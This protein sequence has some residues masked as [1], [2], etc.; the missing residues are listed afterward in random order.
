MLLA[1]VGFTEETVPTIHLVKDYGGAPRKI[2]VYRTSLKSFDIVNE[3]SF[4][5]QADIPLPND[6]H[7]LYAHGWVHAQ[8]HAPV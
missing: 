3:I 8:R 4:H 7:I 2:Y 1:C 6:T 5:L